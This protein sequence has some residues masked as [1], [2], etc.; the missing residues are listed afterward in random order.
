MG[1]SR[2]CQYTFWQGR[3]RGR[4][5]L[6]AYIGRGSNEARGSKGKNQDQEGE[7]KSYRS[8]YPAATIARATIR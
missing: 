3:E 6:P 5:Y 7:A 8:R 2:F 4:L 1:R